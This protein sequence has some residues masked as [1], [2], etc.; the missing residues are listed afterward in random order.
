MIIDVH[1]HLPIRQAPDVP[2]FHWELVSL[3]EGDISAED[4][5]R[6]LRESQIDK[7]I[8]SSLGANTG[9]TFDELRASNRR[10]AELARDYPDQFYCCCSVSP[11]YLDE[12][13]E[14]MDYM[15]KERGAICIGEVCPHVQT[16]EMDSPE[17]RAIIAKA[18]DLDIP[19]NLHS[20]EPEHF[21][22]IAKLAKEF[23]AA[24][25]FMAHFGGFRFWKDGIEAIK[26][27]DNVWA[28]CSAWVL[29]TAGAFESTIR[30]IGA[31]RVLFGTDFP[32]CE[33]D[34]AVWKLQHSGLSDKDCELISSGNAIELFGLEL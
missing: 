14:E 2:G 25:I 8:I 19:L 10:V 32:I 15:V 29:F 22:A 11:H 20:S 33:L 26:D 13:L 18:V 3:P 17:V 4:V 12:S 23:P 34:M 21:Q 27:C 24:K 5:A 30:K 6:I 7:M 31:S 9:P 1:A 16:F 28:D